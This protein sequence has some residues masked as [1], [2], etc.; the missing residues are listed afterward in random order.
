M[1]LTAAP[2][3]KI[4]LRWGSAFQGPAAKR[5]LGATSS[6]S[7]RSPAE[8]VAFATT[9]SPSPRRRPRPPYP[10]SRPPRPVCA[11]PFA[12]RGV[13]REARL[14]S[15]HD[16]AAEVSGDRHLRPGVR[17]DLSFRAPLPSTERGVRA[18]GP[19]TLVSPGSLHPHAQSV[20]SKIGETGVPSSLPWDRHRFATCML[21]ASVNS[22]LMPRCAC[23]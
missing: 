1:P 11:R 14:A 2:C 18:V 17:R 4:A 20:F 16:P 6:S 3:P 12:R 9:R 10:D 7:R 21:P 23:I 19:D 22:F 8:T 5:R 13:T 15:G